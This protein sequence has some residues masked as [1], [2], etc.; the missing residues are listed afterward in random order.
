[1]RPCFTDPDGDPLTIFATNLSNEY[2]IDLAAACIFLA[3]A[4]NELVRNTG[5]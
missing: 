3:N 4:A 1:L 5:D 2:V